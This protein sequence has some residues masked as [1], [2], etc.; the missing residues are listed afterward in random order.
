MNFQIPSAGDMM[1]EALTALTAASR[2]PCRPEVAHFTRT[3]IKDTHEFERRG[4]LANK[5][6][7]ILN[8]CEAK[9]SQALSLR[10]LGFAECLSVFGFIDELS[11]KEIPK[12][13]PREGYP[14]RPPVRR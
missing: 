9:I 13:W 6:M 10:R 4:E 11:L 7:A 2:L 12:L 14:P 5:V 1:K 8:T 3:G